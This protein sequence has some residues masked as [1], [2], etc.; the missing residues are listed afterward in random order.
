MSWVSADTQQNKQQQKLR[1]THK[2]YTTLLIG[3]DGGHTKHSTVAAAV[4][5]RN[6]IDE[7][8]SSL[9]LL[10]RQR[11][12]SLLHTYY[13]FNMIFEWIFFRNF[14][15]FLSSHQRSVITIDLYTSFLEHNCKYYRFIGNFLCTFQITRPSTLQRLNTKPWWKCQNTLHTL[16][17]NSL[18]HTRVVNANNNNTHTEVSLVGSSILSVLERH[19]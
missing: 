10:Q 12:T 3:M 4:R 6:K 15:I 19:S 13:T 9:L 16:K 8:C 7:F 17:E 11:F 18:W 5:Q 14:S 1:S 2:K